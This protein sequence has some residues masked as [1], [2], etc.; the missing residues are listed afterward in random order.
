MSIGNLPVG[1]V[2]IRQESNIE[3]QRISDCFQLLTPEEIEQV[4]E[5]DFIWTPV[6]LPSA[7]PEHQQKK[8]FVKV[9]IIMAELMSS[10]GN[11]EKNFT[12]A[13]GKMT[14]RCCTSLGGSVAEGGAFLHSSFWKADEVLLQE[15]LVQHPQAID[16]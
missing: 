7:A 10:W 14:S 15:L 6:S 2:V 5:G 1:T 11:P 9:E 4:E 12:Y 16:L 3:F 8:C 13:S